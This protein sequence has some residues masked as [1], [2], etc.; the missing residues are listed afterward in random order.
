MGTTPEQST[1]VPARRRFARLRRLLW[2]SAG[3]GKPLA[4]MSPG[5]AVGRAMLFTL[6]AVSL[7]GTVMTT[8]YLPGPWGRLLVLPAAVGALCT[9]LTACFHAVVASFAVV[10]AAHRRG[11][12]LKQTVVHR[13]RAGSAAAK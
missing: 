5:R 10:E 4:A 3:G 12:A 11:A 13:R 7:V 6:L 9:G 1:A 2:R 8:I